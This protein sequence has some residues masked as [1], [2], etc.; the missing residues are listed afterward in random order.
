MLNRLHDVLRTAGHAI[1]LLVDQAA[2]VSVPLLLF[3][4]VLYIFSQCVRTLGWYTILRAS[5]PDADELKRR[6]VVKAYLA[7]SGLNAVIPARGGDA[8]KLAIV[9]RHI[10]DSRYSTLIATFVPETLFETFFGTALVVWALAR[11]FL[12]VPNAV[13]EVPSYDV[14]LFVEHPVIS[15]V[16]TVAALAA[17][18][19]L[20]RLLRARGRVTVGRVKQGLAV[21]S[22]PKLFL[23]GVVS[24]QALARLIRLGSLAAFMGAFS[25]PVT[26]STVVLVMAAQGGGRII[27]LAPASTGLRLAML[28]YGFVEVTHQAVDIAAI[29]TFTFGVGAVLMLSGLVIALTIIFLEFGTLSPRRAVAAARNLVGPRSPAPTT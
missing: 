11:G 28:S 12:P 29:T 4:T 19:G 1:S 9:H 14:S 6:D 24:W 7:G 17:M 15:T 3:G 16:A 13:G 8:V 21:F 22:S 5:Y 26:L 27:P 10:P 25:L 2:S 20:W 23:T 18:Y